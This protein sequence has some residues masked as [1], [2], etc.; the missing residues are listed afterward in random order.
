MDLFFEH[1]QVIG[2]LFFFLVFVGIAVSVMRPSVKIRLE[3][4]AKIPLQ[5][6]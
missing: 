3:S 4:L 1:A 2:L 5:E 6:D